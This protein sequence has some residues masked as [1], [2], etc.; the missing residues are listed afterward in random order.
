MD[1]P[2]SCSNLNQFKL[3]HVHLQLSVC[4][5]SK[6][7]AGHVVLEFER[8]DPEAEH[9]HLD[10]LA[11]DCERIQLG[12][13]EIPASEWTMQPFTDFGQRLTIPVPKASSK[14]Q[15][16]IHYQTTSAS[17]G[18]CFLDPAQTA[19]QTHPYLYTQGQEVLNRSVFPCQDSPS[20]RITYTADI[21]VPNPLTCVMSAKCLGST[22][23]GDERTVFSYRMDQS[24]PVYL[25]AM[26]IGEIQCATIGPRSKVWT[27]P[28]MLE[29]AKHE[30][31]GETE[32]YL[33]TGEQLLFVGNV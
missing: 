9:V 11:L 24:I 8:L 15:F 26:A 23:G 28:C 4:F 27:E 13:D 29:A 1:D 31:E 10:S 3:L 5:Q 32:L 30:F 16:T 22:P 33:A 6:T 14:F 12:E 17:P 25:V 20:V 2:A 21:S 19:G 7:M 18:L